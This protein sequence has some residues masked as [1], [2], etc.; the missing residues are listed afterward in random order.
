MK[1]QLHHVAMNVCDLKWYTTFFQ[2]VFGMEIRKTS[3]SAPN[4]K[5]WFS[6]GI[7]L[8]E[9]RDA[10]DVGNAYDHIS[11][12]VADVSETVRAAL[13]AG[14]TQL[15]DGAHWFA[16]PNGIRIELMCANCF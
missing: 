16:L 10:A 4:Q 3:G 5:I 7:Q 11:I 1:S 12:S 13:R 8:N 15:P 9:C 14:C 6:A 2:D